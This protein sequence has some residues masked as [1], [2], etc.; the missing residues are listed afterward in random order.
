MR[1][2]SESPEGNEQA[3]TTPTRSRSSTRSKSE[4]ATPGSQEQATKV[5]RRR[6]TSASN[7][8]GSVATSNSSETENKTTPAAPVSRPAPTQR[9][10]TASSK[11][12]VPP[13]QL[14]KEPI[15][16]TTSP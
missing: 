15:T 13:K 6:T 3:K 11:T 7:S 4:S 8:D 2:T 12:S 9:A 14:D 16:T 5:T 10:G 1:N